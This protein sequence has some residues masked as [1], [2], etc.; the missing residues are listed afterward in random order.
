MADYDILG[1][2]AVIKSEG[3]K[4]KQAMIEADKIFS[5]HLGVRTVLSKDNKV[6]GRLRTI[7]AKHVKGEKN[8]IVDYIENNCRFVFDIRKCYFSPRLSGE[9]KLIAEKIKSNDKVLVMFAGIGVYPIVIYKI[10]KPVQVLGAEIGRECCK[11]FKKNLELNKIP[12]DKVKIIQ[13][14]VKKKIKKD[15]GKFEV[16]VMAR[17]NLKD[18]FLEQGLY[19]SKKGTRLFY[20]AFS[21]NDKID[22]VIRDLIK[23]AGRYKRNI[24]FIEKVTAGD[25]A[26]YKYHYR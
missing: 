19:T 11:Y 4:K 1:N 10:A 2:I 9:R 16:V 23:E 3:K 7:K 26:P 15:F 8:F 5:S 14:D 18:S 17:P 21:K 20:Y 22:E 24:K 13:G 12:S 6:S 25:I